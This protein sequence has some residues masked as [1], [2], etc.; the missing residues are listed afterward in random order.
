MSIVEDGPCQLVS[1]T[2]CVVPSGGSKHWASFRVLSMD[3]QRHGQELNAVR[4]KECASSRTRA[5]WRRR[6]AGV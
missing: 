3:S 6:Q 2:E 4:A 5:R 1:K